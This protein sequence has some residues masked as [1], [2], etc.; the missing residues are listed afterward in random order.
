MKEILSV[1]T[2]CVLSLL[3]A[4]ASLPAAASD[5]PRPNAVGEQGAYVLGG[6]ATGRPATSMVEIVTR[7]FKT[8]TVGENIRLY[9]VSFSNQ[10]GM[11]VV[12]NLFVPTESSTG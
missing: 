6:D 11:E 7:N 9:R 8:F 2:G 3:L 10:Y 4:L 12:G 5:S 1:Q